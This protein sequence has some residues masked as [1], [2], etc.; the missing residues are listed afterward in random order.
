MGA[1]RHARECVGMVFGCVGQRVLWKKPG[2]RPS[3]HWFG[4]Q[5]RVSWGQLGRLCLVLSFG[6]PLR[7]LSVGF[8][9]L[10]G[11]P[12]L[13]CPQVD[14]FDEKTGTSR[15]GRRA[16]AGRAPKGERGRTMPGAGFFWFE[17]SFVVGRK[18]LR[19]ET[20]PPGGRTRR[21]AENLQANVVPQPCLPFGGT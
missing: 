17:P 18:W 19:N 3:E 6:L 7:V 8:G 4:L 20:F 21:E 11:L 13:P 9:R 5:P 14:P 15:A 1:F 10:S 12:C 16:W 2:A